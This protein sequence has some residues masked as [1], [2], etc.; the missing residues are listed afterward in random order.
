MGLDQKPGAPYIGHFDRVCPI[1]EDG[2][3][4]DLTGTLQ[5]EARVAQQE[6]GTARIPGLIASG[7]SICAA[8]VVV[9]K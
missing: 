1:C 5:C 3:P 2:I 8:I 7:E 4:A 6:E 9:L